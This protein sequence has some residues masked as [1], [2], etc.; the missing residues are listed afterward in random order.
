M[1]EFINYVFILIYFLTVFFFYLF[2]AQ[3]DGN[4]NKILILKY[5]IMKCEQPFC[6]N[7]EFILILNNCYIKRA[8]WKKV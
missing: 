1:I 2:N 5:S 7:N 4:D 6:V 3:N 8:M